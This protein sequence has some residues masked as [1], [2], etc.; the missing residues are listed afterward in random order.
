MEGA[1]VSGK[2]KYEKTGIPD[3]ISIEEILPRLP[4]KSIFRFR[5]VC[6]L[7]ESLPY[8]PWFVQLHHSRSPS[9]SNVIVLACKARGNQCFLSFCSLETTESG[10]R[11]RMMCTIPLNIDVYA[12]E[13]SCN[14]L[15]CFSSL[16]RQDIFVGNPSTQEF[17]QLP[18]DIVGD[19]GGYSPCKVAGFGFDQSSGR[20]KVVCA[21]SIP[22][23]QKSKCFIFTLGCIDGKWRQ[24]NDIPYCILPM[25]S[26]Y[27]N[28][29][30]HWI[31]ESNLYNSPDGI[32][33]FNFEDETY[34]VLSLPDCYIWESY[35]LFSTMGSHA[36]LKALGGY[37]HLFTTL[38]GS[39]AGFWQFDVWALKD[40]PNNVWNHELVIVFDITSEALK[41]QPPAPVDIQNG[42]VLLS[43]GNQLYAY[44]VEKMTQSEIECDFLDE[45]Y[46]K[47]YQ[48]NHVETLV[49]VYGGY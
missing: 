42:K 47:V 16:L 49:S 10:L 2:E 18:K 31:I 11:T 30:V 5:S 45:E 29:A 14:G 20:Y 41:F 19:G 1:V 26:A 33:S 12:M 28:G 6:K 35:L 27:L 44:D 21:F 24:L 8:D 37:L 22:L 17:I 40:Y 48:A 46:T 9:A 23:E 32:I 39:A 13:P 15:V 38:D 36:Y 4:V 25:Q 43:A 34:G 3:M 7:W